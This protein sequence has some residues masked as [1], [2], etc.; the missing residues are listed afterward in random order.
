MAVQEAL[1]DKRGNRHAD[2]QLTAAIKVAQAHSAM[3][4]VEIG[5]PTPRSAVRLHQM[6]K[7][8][9]NIGIGAIVALSDVGPAIDQAQEFIDWAQTHWSGEL[10]E[11]QRNVE[12]PWDTWPN[13]SPR[14][15]TEDELQREIGR[16]EGWEPDDQQIGEL[17][18]EARDAEDYRQE[19]IDELTDRENRARAEEEAA[20]QRFEQLRESRA[21]RE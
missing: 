19:L 14:E 18:A 10:A 6:T 17:L 2:R 13:R 7:L 8:V 9:A 5:D 3:L 4:G 21:F 12:D 15:M 11:A 20:E 16:V 1:P